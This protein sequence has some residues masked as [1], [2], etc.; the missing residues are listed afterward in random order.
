MKKCMY[1]SRFLVIITG[2]LGFAAA[3]GPVYADTLEQCATDLTDALICWDANATPNGFV[4]LRRTKRGIVSCQVG[5]N[6]T[7]FFQVDF[8]GFW[9]NPL[10]T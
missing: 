4:Q 1:A 5:Q 3:P 9:T 6:P 10:K 7:L 2:I 8:Q